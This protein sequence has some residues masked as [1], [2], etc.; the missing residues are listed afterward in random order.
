MK[1]NK[2]LHKFSLIILLITSL[3]SVASAQR[4]GSHV[5]RQEKLLNGLKVLMW[6]DPAAAKVDVRLRIHSGAAFDPQGKE[7][8]MQLLADNLFPNEALREFFRDD[9]GGSLEIAANY[10]YIQITASSTPDKILPLLETLAT[11]VSNPTIDKETTAKLKSELLKKVSTKIL[12]PVYVADH[13]VA[14]KLFGTFPYG[15]PVSG[16]PSSI[17]KIDFADLIEARQRFLTSDNVTLAIRGNVDSNVIYRAVRRYFGSWLKSDKLS[18]STFRQPDAPKGAMSIVESPET[19]KSEF[20]YAIRG[21]AHGDKDYYASAIV[22]AI[23]DRRFK[24]V[25]GPN[26]SVR[27]ETNTL[28]GAFIFA[29]SDWNLDRIKRDGDKISVPDTNGY[30]T[31]TFSKPITASEFETAKRE[32]V[33]RSAQENIVEGW[34]D[35]HTYN[36]G[37]AEKR[38]EDLQAVTLADAQSVLARLQKEPVAYVL[39]WGESE[40]IKVDAFRPKR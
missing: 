7:G 35:T 32:I 34:L 27:H 14:A 5:P 16:T 6:T 23:L 25:E 28:P 1:S 31:R 12:D 3:V 4:P 40:P 20:R 13:A 11:A 33:V 18:P 21:L 17:A 9:L 38:S 36:L 29:V 15:R 8:R 19:R 24:Q 30:Q 26:A 10:D 37:T 22:A 2:S 39:V